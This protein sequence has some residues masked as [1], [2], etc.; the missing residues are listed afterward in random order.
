[1]GPPVEL[2]IT[3]FYSFQTGIL[4]SGYYPYGPGILDYG[5]S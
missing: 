4:I 1:M 2:R 5:E 3:I